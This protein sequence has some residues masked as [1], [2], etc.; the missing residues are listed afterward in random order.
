[1]VEFLVAGV[2]L[3]LLFGSLCWLGDR[4]PRR[5]RCQV[6]HTPLAESH[7]N[8]LGALGPVVVLCVDCAAVAMTIVEKRA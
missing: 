1:M 6:C 3:A 5:D 2:L 4:P 7:A 8:R